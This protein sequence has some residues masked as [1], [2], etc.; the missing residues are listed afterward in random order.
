MRIDHVGVAV[1]DIREGIRFY[2]EA[3]GLSVLH[4]EEVAAQKVRVA[5]LGEPGAEASIELLEPLGAE[6]A[7]AKFLAERGPGMH[8]VAFHSPDIAGD[9]ARLRAGGRPPLDA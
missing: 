8:H 2:S 3:L 7:V 6:G 5:F 9:M 1:K 4:E